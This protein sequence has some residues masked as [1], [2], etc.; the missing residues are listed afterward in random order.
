MSRLQKGEHLLRKKGVQ[1]Q[2]RCDGFGTHPIQEWDSQMVRSDL[3][4]RPRLCPLQVPMP[5]RS[6][7]TK[8]IM[9]TLCAA[10]Q[11]CLERVNI[12]AGAVRADLEN[13]LTAYVDESFSISKE[14][15][16]TNEGNRLTAVQK[17]SNTRI[18]QKHTYLK[19]ELNTFEVK[20]NA[21]K[22]VWSSW[23]HCKHRV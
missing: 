13:L 21:Y 7:K 1:W 23:R 6:F 14:L 15:L 17:M 3:S 8:D 9:A 18:N 10:E 22:S 20:N 12:K 5:V 11:Y 16:D 19:D 4:R 2:F